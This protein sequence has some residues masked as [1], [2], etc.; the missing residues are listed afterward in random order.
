MF[1]NT[2][3]YIMINRS[4]R[5]LKNCKHQWKWILIY[6]AYTAFSRC[7][8]VRIA[9]ATAL[10]LLCIRVVARL[11]NHRR[12]PGAAPSFTCCPRQAFPRKS[13]FI[14]TGALPAPNNRG[15]GV[16][17]GWGKV[18][19]WRGVW[20]G[21]R[22]SRE[23]YFVLRLRGG[24]AR[25][26]VRVVGRAVWDDIFVLFFVFCFIF[27]QSSHQRNSPSHYNHYDVSVRADQRLC[28]RP[29]V[30][31]VVKSFAECWYII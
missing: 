30:V 22:R 19:G 12:S 20:G 27:R 23:G 5:S 24:S 7:K 16:G 21:G 25:T 28:R 15:R 4:I 14:G 26:V 3:K 18:V 29:V 6:H 9:L 8:R 13:R 11:Y 31:Y 1:A 2:Q 17:G 10:W